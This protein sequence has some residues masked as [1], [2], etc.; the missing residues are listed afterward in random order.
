MGCCAST[1]PKQGEDTLEKNNQLK[2]VSATTNITPGATP[3]EI[4]PI[5]EE[6]LP[7]IEASPNDVA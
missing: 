6:D 2:P 5:V 7:Q 1:K 3:G 4:K